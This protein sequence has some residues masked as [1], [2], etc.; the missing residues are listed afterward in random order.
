[1][2]AANKD[3]LIDVFLDLVRLSSP[4][5]D[6]RAVADYLID[7]AKKL[8]VELEEDAAGA[9][10]DGTC[11][12]LVGRLGGRDTDRPRLL[13]V[14]HM[15]T[16]G[17]CDG[18]EPVVSDGKIRSAGPT[19]LGGDNKVAVAAMLEMMAVLG[20]SA[21]PHVPVTFC[22]TVAE[23]K[24]LMGAHQLDF[25]RLD[26][27]CAFV[28]DG[29]GMPGEVIVAAPT[30]V[31]YRVECR[32]R[33]AHAGVAPERGINAIQIAA[34]AISR[35]D[36]G[37]IDDETT[38]N[39]GMVNGGTATNVVPDFAEVRGEV[40]SHGRETVIKLVGHVRETFQEVAST[41]GG[42]IEFSDTIEYE[43]FR[44]PED[45]Q[46]LRLARRAA[47]ACGLDGGQMVSNGGSDAS[48]LNAGGIP[49]AVLATGTEDVHSKEETVHIGRL[50]AVAN[51]TL[52]IV[53]EA[54]GDGGN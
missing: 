35:L 45:S 19:I 11:G 53:A 34:A 8:G 48:V 31:T 24:G 38:A 16:V 21:D 41:Y 4:S 40:R 47:A 50:V 25:E 20:E 52:A 12:N 10:I 43:A 36:L 26:A 39:V 30:H 1:M 28:P 17:P 15:D 5:R 13:F 42:E 22:F 49:T 7:R 14:A 54:S 46:P 32:G 44:L 37:R 23:E 2:F 6:E 3:R 33:A 27:D 18:V 51:W 29:D 9:A